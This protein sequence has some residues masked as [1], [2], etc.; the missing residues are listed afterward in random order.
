MIKALTN[1]LTPT[2]H[3]VHSLQLAMSAMWWSRTLM[4]SCAYLLAHS[5]VVS[6]SGAAVQQLLQCGCGRGVG[7]HAQ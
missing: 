2:E 3:L 5:A 1:I 4:H 6:V 7:R